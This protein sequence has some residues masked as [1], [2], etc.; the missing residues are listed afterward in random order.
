M[1][2]RLVANSERVE[3][4]LCDEG[5][6]IDSTKELIS[7]IIIS[8]MF[9]REDSLTR[10]GDIGLDYD[11]E[12]LLESYKKL[13]FNVGE[14]YRKMLY[15]LINETNLRWTQE[16]EHHR[17]YHVIKKFYRHLEDFP[18]QLLKFQLTLYDVMKRA[19]NQSEDR[20]YSKYN[21][22]SIPML[23]QESLEEWIIHFDKIDPSWKNSAWEN[24]DI[25]IKGN[26]DL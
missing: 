10:E 9:S 17:V 12:I 4:Y 26:N 14:I 22:S 15:N 16:A 21:Y 13:G 11:I 18:Q 8:R 7:D 1:K 2:Q 6:R 25:W 24:Y 3:K 5:Y 20:W 19:S 23:S